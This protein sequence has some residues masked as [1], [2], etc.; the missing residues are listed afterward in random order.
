[1]LSLDVLLSC[2]PGYVGEQCEIYDPCARNP[3]GKSSECVAIP[4]E[5]EVKG[6]LSAQNYR[7]LCGMAEDIDEENPTGES[8][9]SR[10]GYSLIL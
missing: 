5:T 8:A 7:C 3:C 2:R 9:G 4:D 6:D 10:N 1:M